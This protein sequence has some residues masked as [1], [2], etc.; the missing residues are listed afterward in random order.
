MKTFRMELNEYLVSTPTQGYILQLN[1]VVIINIIKLA[2]KISFTKSKF[3]DADQ[4]LGRIG[5]KKSDVTM[6]FKKI[7]WSKLFLICMGEGDLDGKTSQNLLI[8]KRFDC[9]TLH[10]DKKTL[11]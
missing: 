4:G 9:M 5:M 6:N 10:I 7:T 2:K 1:C 3:Y 8:L 11:P